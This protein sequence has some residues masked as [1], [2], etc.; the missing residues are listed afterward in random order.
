MKAATPLAFVMAL[1]VAHG[2]FGPRAA[3]VAAGSG[4]VPAA[5]ER[6]VYAAMRPPNWDLYLFEAAGAAPRALAAHPALDYNAA[7]SPDGRWLVF[8]SERRG[9]PDLYVLDLER[10]GQPRLLTPSPALEDAAA[11]S[12]DGATLAFVSTREGNADV[13][14]MAFRPEGPEASS[15][16]VNLTRHPS[17]DFNPAW[18][19]DGRRLAFSSDRDGRRASEVYVMSADGSDSRRLTHAPGWD[20]S[21]AWTSDGRRILF[22]SDERGGFWSVDAGGG[23]PERQPGFEG[24]VLSPAVG[25]GGRIAACI[26]RRDGAWRIVSMAPDGSGERMESDEARDYWSPA[27]HPLTGRIVAHGPGP[28]EPGPTLGRRSPRPLVVGGERDAVSLPDRTVRL[29]PLRATFPS[30]DPAGS[31]LVADEQFGAILVAG[32]D[33]GGLRRIL[34]PAEGQAWSPAWGAEGWIYFSLGPT[35]AGPA[36]GVDVWRVRE[37]GTGAANLTP[38]SP[39]N[40]AFPGVSADGRRVVFRSGR[41]GNHEVYLAATDGARPRRLTDHPATDTMPA[42]APDGRQVAFASDRDGDFEIYTLDLDREGRPEAPRRATTS[43]GLDM[44]PKYSPDGRWIVFASARGGWNDE[45][46]LIPIYNPQPY[47]EIFALRLADGLTVRLTHNKWEDG[48]PSW[49]RG[50]A[51]TGGE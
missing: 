26:Q 51:P 3:P 10:P 48:T 11:L 40:D 9:N 27:V 29:H 7:F 23:T 37:D 34:T 49:G 35:F 4:P 19:P 18:S 42:I 32:L 13:F 43:P 12:P 20:G 24:R 15:E 39:G 30:L 47:G 31:S 25:R 14:R 8:T 36:A 45:D 16:A 50:A 17:G 46:P 38:G 21:P 44:H 41:D 2:A 22:S 33:G 5:V 1:A 28:L 6:I